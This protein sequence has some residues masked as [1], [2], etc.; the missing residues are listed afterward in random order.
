[1]KTLSD[2]QTLKRAFI[3][4]KLKSLP[5]SRSAL[6]REVCSGR[7]VVHLGERYRLSFT[8]TCIVLK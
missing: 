7:V 8:Y 5:G 4:G 1:M 6:G 3:S 2:A